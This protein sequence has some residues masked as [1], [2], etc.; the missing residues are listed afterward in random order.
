MA[1]GSDSEILEKI[2]E[3]KTEISTV[4][5]TLNTHVKPEN[6]VSDDEFAAGKADIKKAIKEGKDET[7]THFEALMEAI[8]FKDFFEAFKQMD[9]I[10]VAVLLVGAG[11][12]LVKDKVLNFGKLLNT[13][14]EKI[15]GKIF[16]IG[17]NGA[18]TLQTR[19]ATQAAQS[20]S[21]NP[22]NLT[23]E[24]LGALQT[25]LSTV[26][27]EIRDFNT[28]IGAMKSP[29]QIK[30]ITK[31][32]G[33]LKAKL[34]PSPKAAIS[35]TAKAIDKLSDQLDRYDPTKL[36]RVQTMH[37]T[38]TA[39][40]QLSTAAGTLQDRLRNLAAEARTTA[41]AVGPS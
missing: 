6:H 41:G 21:I 7:K 26:T 29:A 9:K 13:V 36:P 33:D 18:P 14:V 10:T 15:T 38:A 31:A 23:P 5:S 20:V 40:G 12:A 4:K 37:E 39:V 11:L 35:D 17:E 1:S 30:K 34:T 22:T 28:A 32:V 16:S 25:A 27:P 2:A 24:T 19:A 3:L 8:G